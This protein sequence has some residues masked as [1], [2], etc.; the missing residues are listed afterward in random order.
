MNATC[1]KGDPVSNNWNEEVKLNIEDAN[2]VTQRHVRDESDSDS[3]DDNER[4]SSNRDD[5]IRKGFNIRFSD[6]DSISPQ[7]S[8]IAVVSLA[9]TM[10]IKY[11]GNV[12]G[13]M[14]DFVRGVVKFNDS[15]NN[16]QPFKCKHMI[17]TLEAEEQ[18]AASETQ[19]GTEKS[20]AALSRKVYYES[21]FD[22]VDNYF[23]TSFLIPIPLTAQT[24]PIAPSPAPT[25][26]TRAFALKWMVRFIF[27]IV[28]QRV[29]N[30]SS[31]PQSTQERK[32]LNWT[33]PLL[34]LPPL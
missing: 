28:P 29:S 11:A 32:E 26:A 12:I 10:S 22:N 9:N 13:N 18:M 19:K 34:V 21:T 25:F 4:E 8:T 24:T 6:D 5:F 16:R 7:Q 20:F 14:G 33:L 17:I 15:T 3:D 31:A 1:S 2:E 23:E 30:E 27:I